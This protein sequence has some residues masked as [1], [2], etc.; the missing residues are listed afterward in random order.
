LDTVGLDS[1]VWPGEEWAEAS[2]E[3]VGLDR[4]HLAEIRDYARESSPQITSLLIVRH[5]Y[6]VF[7]E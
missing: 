4:S 1:A 2:P 5:G 3:D 6:L 7:E